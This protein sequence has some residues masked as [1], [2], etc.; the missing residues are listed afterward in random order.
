M[1]R[2]ERV[3]KAY[4][5]RGGR[6]VVLDNANAVFEWGTIS[7]SSGSTVPANQH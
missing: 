5:T 3:A 7:A 4:R 2:L 1:I 6:R